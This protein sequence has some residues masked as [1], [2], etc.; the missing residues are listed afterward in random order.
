MARG[1]YW[2]NNGPRQADYDRLVKELVP[3]SGKADTR[4]GE[5]LRASGQLGYDF[6]N[7]GGGNNVSGGL[8]FLKEHYP[9]FKESWWTALAP[10]VTGRVKDDLEDILPVC[11]DIVDKVTAYVV[12]RNGKYR[13]NEFD[14]LDFTVKETGLEAPEIESYDGDPDEDE[15]HSHAF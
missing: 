14:M 11:E 5:L 3:A 12:K 13:D 10:N 9:G 7:N 8:R 4:E 1:R 15:E 2:D 6:Y